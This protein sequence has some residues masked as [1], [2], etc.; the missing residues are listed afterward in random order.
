MQ[1]VLIVKGKGQEGEGV[2][3][4]ACTA[5]ALMLPSVIK[6]HASEM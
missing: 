1:D 2:G 3:F 4:V 6:C 5:T